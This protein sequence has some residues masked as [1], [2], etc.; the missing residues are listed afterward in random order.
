MSR[1]FIYLSIL[2]T[3]TAVGLKSQAAEIGFEEACKAEITSAI[4]GWK[5]STPANDLAAYAKTKNIQTNIARADF[6]DDGSKDL[7]FLVVSPL[8]GANA[9]QYIAVCLNKSGKTQLHLIKGPSC[10]DG[11]D[12]SPKGKEFYNYE[13]NK[14]GKYPANG[15]SAYCFEKAGATYLFQNG[16]FRRVMDSD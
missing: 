1:L 12:V 8:V 6:D 5:L 15:I 16:I 10:G 2:A 13:T 7:A 14:T 11:I 4:P 3:L 9:V